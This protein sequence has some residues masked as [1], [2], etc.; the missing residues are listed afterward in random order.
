MT[1]KV[2]SNGSCYSPFLIKNGMKREELR[3]AYELKVFDYADIDE[4]GIIKDNEYNRMVCADGHYPGEKI[5]DYTYYDE[6][7][8]YTVDTNKDGEITKDELDEYVNITLATRLIKEEYREKINETSFHDQKGSFVLG[9][10]GVTTSFL[11]K[12]ALSTKVPAVEEYVKAGYTK[13]TAKKLTNILAHKG[14]RIFGKVGM[15]LGIIIAGLS[16]I[17]IYQGNKEDAK[18]NALKYEYA[19]KMSSA[20]AAFPDS[21]Y[22]KNLNNEF[23]EYLFN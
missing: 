11:A 6:N 17:D 15:A 23:Q 16:A 4:D 12:K 13:E 9:I 21:E 10:L 22:A 19:N 2:L 3:Y 1:S 8:W 14:L 18:R 7:D 5:T 20:T